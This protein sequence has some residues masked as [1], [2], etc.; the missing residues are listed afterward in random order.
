MKIDFLF[1]SE[2]IDPKLKIIFHPVDISPEKMDI[3]ST[4]EG[5]HPDLGKYRIE[6]RG[7]V[8]IP[9][10]KK[11]EHIHFVR[12]QQYKGIIL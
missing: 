8:K 3:V 10:C 4:Y 9:K 11:D 2:P 6:C 12:F 1:K 7:S 5:Y